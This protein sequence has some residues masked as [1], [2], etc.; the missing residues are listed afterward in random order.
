MLNALTFALDKTP[1]KWINVNVNVCVPVVSVWTRGLSDWTCWAALYHHGGKTAYQQHSRVCHTVGASLHIS[2]W[3]TCFNN[4][5]KPQLKHCRIEMT[6][7]N[8]RTASQHW[9]LHCRSMLQHWHSEQLGILLLRKCV[10]SGFA[11]ILGCIC[12]RKDNSTYLIE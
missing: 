2:C 3:Y 8:L 5:L 1:G 10:L 7:S 6:L 4:L 11:S 12:P 9:V